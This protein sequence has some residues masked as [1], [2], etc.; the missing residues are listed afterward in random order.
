MEQSQEPAN[1]SEE[2][3][4]KLEQM[5]GKLEKFKDEL[6]SKFENY[7]VGVALLPP[8]KEGQDGEKVDKNKVN[9]LVVVDDS[10]S[11]RQ[12]KQEL[13]EKVERAVQKRAEKIDKNLAPQ[14]MMQGELWMSCLDQ[15]YDI[16][17]L[18]AMSA[19]AYDTGLLGGVKPS[20][21]HKNMVLKKFEK[22]IV[23]YVLTGS[24][25]RGEA[26]ETSDV[27]VMVIIDDTDVKKMTRAELKD[28]LRGII[29]GMGME[30]GEATGMPNKLNI[31]VYIL[32]DFWDNLKEAN[33]VIFTLLRDGIPFY[34]RGT[35]IPW[36]QLLQMGK[37]KP[38]QEAIDMFMSS[39][40]QMI[41][42]VEHKIK[43]IGMEDIYYSILTPSQAALMLYGIPPPA[44]RETARLMDE[45]F[46]KKENM[47]EEKYVQILSDTIQVRKDIEHGTMEKVSG[48]KVDQMIKNAEKYLKRIEKLFK[49]IE[50]S[51]EKGK[52][53]QIYDDV[54]TVTRDV[55]KT[56]GAKKATEKNIVEEFKNSAVST[57]E[58]P[59]KYLTYLKDV[60]KAK[61]DYSENK[62]NKS[63]IEKVSKKSNEYVRYM[64]EFMQ[65]KRGAELEKSKVRIKHGDKYAEV[66]M[67][68]D[69]A[70]IIPNVDEQEKTVKKGEIK[71]SGIKNIKDSSD[72][73]MESEIANA[74][75]PNKAVLKEQMIEDL[76]EFFGKEIE[77]LLS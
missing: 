58:I 67:L 35:F 26:T 1:L 61:K 52:I 8:P 33:P 44:P 47:L 21:V 19:P 64:V 38:S 11:I 70:F 16:L 68:K 75:L 13:K 46:V 12:N 23:S 36:K 74:K 25:V 55:L 76:K 69:S 22:Y 6:L 29:V 53:K 32:T 72:K 56:I 17:Q 43:E 73:E 5:K 45:I 40:D 77:I 7:L 18:I 39:G 63:D 14:V 27:D 42:R 28:K 37:I 15:K 50:G 48:K 66:I 41:R 34:D 4:Q 59:Q 54:I 3:K 30:A 51:S 24:L 49:Q 71:E 31:Q 57:G 60:I 10:D 65:R 62:L 20:E 9:V 2:A